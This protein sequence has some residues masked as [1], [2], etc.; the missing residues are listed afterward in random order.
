M[1]NIT[2]FQR[3]F[4]EARLGHTNYFGF[5]LSMGTFIIV[6]YAYISANIPII[7]NIF[8]YLWAFA[9][10]AVVIYLPVAI[11]VGHFHLKKQVPIEQIRVFEKSPYFAKMFRIQLQLLSNDIKLSKDEVGKTVELL[12][13]IESPS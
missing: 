8:P 11:I 6:S 13:K 5:L 10:S 12:K 1:V 3:R 2:W 4:Y 7:L 9:L